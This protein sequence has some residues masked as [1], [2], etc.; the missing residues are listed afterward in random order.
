MRTRLLIALTLTLAALLGACAAPAARPPDAT[1]TP[2]TP[3]T[4]TIAPTPTAVPTPPSAAALA[5]GLT[6]DIGGR[7]LFIQCAGSPNG[8]TV[9]LEAGLA[10]DS[11][12]WAQVQAGAANFTRV[13]RYDRAG[14]G[15]SDP[16]PTPRDGAAVVA[17]LQALLD[18]AGV[19]GPYILVAHSFGALFARL[20]AA[21]Q[22]D[23][24]RGLVLVD[25]VHEDWWPESLAALPPESPDD[26]QR[27]QSFRRFL[28]EE[29]ADPARNQEGLDI[30]AVAEQV[31]ATAGLGSR[32][33]IVLTASNF[34]V[35][36]PGLPPAVEARLAELFQQELPRRLTE[37]SSDSTQIVV[38][39]S[40]HNI[41]V[42]RPDMIVLGVQAV[43][44]SGR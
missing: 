29:V 24:V 38:P 31:R 14:L 43:L 42:Q 34:D 13:C 35:L 18:R 25:P 41:P 8:S 23:T 19:S 3:P 4:P 10:A 17:D 33:L 27:L 9:L 2:T 36:A 30:P 20:F 16:A 32:P 44:A 6:I 39:E 40:G 26:S 21:A 15:Q 22:P 11:A 5:A 12:Y 37:L 1:P 28:S 7:E